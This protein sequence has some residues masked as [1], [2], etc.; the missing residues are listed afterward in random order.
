MQ[1]LCI[2]GSRA[3]WSAKIWNETVWAEVGE[4]LEGVVER[5]IKHLWG[6]GSINRLGANAYINKTQENF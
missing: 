3:A 1:E 4:Q 5:L 6:G 2:C